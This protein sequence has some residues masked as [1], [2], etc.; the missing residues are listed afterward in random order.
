MNNERHCNSNGKSGLSR[1]GY[2]RNGVTTLSSIRPKLREGE[3]GGRNL[4]QRRWSR[5]SSNAAWMR[6]GDSRRTAW[7]SLRKPSVALRYP[8]YVFHEKDN[9]RAAWRASVSDWMTRW[10]VGI[11]DLE[12]SESSLI[13]VIRNLPGEDVGCCEMS[14]D[15]VHF[16][17]V[18][19][20]ERTGHRSRV[21][22][23]T[24]LSQE[25][26]PDFL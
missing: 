7:I 24:Q 22:V 10:W 5:E 15:E 19:L 2:V 8:S 23:R 4:S 16:S 6:E 21:P 13:R 20:H 26:I 3:F 18:A 17:G 12:T 1:L 14:E 11:V 9:L 25:K